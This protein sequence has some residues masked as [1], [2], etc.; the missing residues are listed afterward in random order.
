MASL[1][2]NVEK[3]SAWPHAARALGDMGELAVPYLPTLASLLGNSSETRDAAADTLVRIGAKSVPSLVELLRDPFASTRVTALRT[4]GR[5]GIEAV[6]HVQAVAL[7]L[8]DEAP[9][10]RA[11]TAQTLASL[12]QEHAVSYAQDLVLLLDE[13]EPLVRAATIIALGGVA[14]AGAFTHAT[15]LVRCL[16]DD[17][18]SVVKALLEVLASLGQQA[19]RSDRNARLVS[20]LSSEVAPFAAATLRARSAA[21]RCAAAEA[22]GSLGAIA[23]PH[24]PILVECLSDANASVRRSAAAALEG[25]RGGGRISELLKGSRKDSRQ[26]ALRS[27]AALGANGSDVVVRSICHSLLRPGA[28]DQRTQRQASGV[29][30]RLDHRA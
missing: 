24:A 10:V 17:D 30:Q 22:L 14:K 28:A 1:L 21:S 15:S 27:V 2:D 26:A 9:T 7:L 13:D 16:E 4:L 12:R 6:T 11:A 3:A 25:S 8:A 23:A 29:L 19:S 5:I 18:A 20:V